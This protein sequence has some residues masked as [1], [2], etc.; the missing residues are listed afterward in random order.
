MTDT[1]TNLLPRRSSVKPTASPAVALPQRTQNSLRQ[2]QLPLFAA[3][4][5]S[6]FTLISPS[7]AAP[8]TAGLVLE[9][10]STDGVSETGGLISSWSDGSG[11]GN[12][13]VASGD[14]QLLTS[15]TP[16]GLPALRFD[17]TGDKLERLHSVNPLT[18][19]PV[20]NGDR[21]MFLVANYPGG[22]SGYAGATYGNGLTSQA[23]GLCIKH[24]TGE[25]VLQGYGPTD[26][27][28]STAGIGGGWMVQTGTVGGGNGTL[29]KD[30]VQISQAAKTYNTV[31]NKLVIGEEIGGLGSVAI[32]VAAVLIYNRELSEGERASVEAYLQTKYLGASAN[33]APEVDITTPSNDS[34]FTAGQSVT[35]SAT[36]T[37]TEDGSLAASIVWTSDLSGS[38]G[39][40]A[41][42]STSV[43]SEGFHTITASATDSGSQTTNSTITVEIGPPSSST[44]PVSSGLVLQLESTDGV[45]APGGQISQWSDLSGLGNHVTA[46]G[47]PQLLAASTPLGLPSL[48]LDGL[49]DKLE[50]VHAGTPLNG[51]PTGNADRSM[52][53][54]VNYPGGSSAFAGATYGNSATAQAFGLGIKHPSGELVLQGYGSPDLVSST[55]GIAAG[56]MVQSGTV[57]GGSGT[58]FKDGVQIEQAA[59]TYNT[60]LDKLVIGEEIGG[61]GFVPM[62]VAALLVYDRELSTSERADVE[63]YLQ[64]KYLTG[65]SGNTPPVVAINTPDDNSAVGA[66]QAINFTGT[67]IDLADGDVSPSIEWTSSIDGP[68]GT[69][70]SIS[71]STL[72]QGVHTITA[73]VIDSDSA[74][75]NANI[76]LTI[77][78]PS[79][80]SLV[81]RW[82]LDEAAGT[83]ATDVKGG[84]NGTLN[85]GPEW[86][87]AEGRLSG[88]LDLAGDA[89]RVVVPPIDVS[90]TGMTIAAWVKPESFAGF[91]DEARFVSKASGTAEADHYWMIGNFGNG[92]AVRFRLKTSDGGTSTLLSSSGVLTLDEWNHV[93]ATYNGSA[94]TLY[95][96]G[97]QVATAAKTGTI[98]TDGTVAV[99]LGNQPAGAGDRGLDGLLDEVTIY[100]RAFSAVEIS[101]LANPSTGSGNSAP[102]VVI[103]APSDGSVFDAGTSINFTA[104]ASD[105]EDGDLSSSIVWSSDKDGVLGTG[106][107]I[108]ESGLSLGA[109]VITASCTDTNS[110]SATGIA[111]VAVN[112]SATDDDDFTLPIVADLSLHL[113]ATE[114]V[115][116]G[117][118]GFVTDW[119]DQSAMGHSVFGGG[120]PMLVPGVTPSGRPVVRLDGINDMFERIHATHPFTL[121][122]SHE[123]RTLIVLASYGTQSTG[124]AGVTWGRAIVNKV[125]G[126][127]T[128]HPGGKLKL[129]GWGVENDF[130]TNVQIQG[131]GWMIQEALM[132]NIRSTVFRDGVSV[133]TFDHDHLTD[134]SNSRK[135]VIGQG[136]NGS[137]HAQMD[138]AAI[139]IYNRAL[140]SSERVSVRNYLYDKYLDDTLVIIDEYGDWLTSFGLAGETD[141]DSDGGGI[142]NRTEFLLG[143]DPTN[144]RDDATFK[145][146]LELGET[147]AILRYPSLKPTG[148]Y[149]LHASADLDAIRDPE[150]RIDTL[151]SAMIEAMDAG[152]RDS[153]MLEIPMEGPRG[154]YLLV[155]EADES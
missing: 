1:N 152:E 8:V 32:D 55:A 120:E 30:G 73:D 140:N 52:F 15:G 61:A 85:G 67:A 56:W 143:L 115:T 132:A 41:S 46:S 10:E 65:G 128:S 11:Q 110:P 119:A 101:G 84:R 146:E 14:P 105:A 103:T 108:T 131:A 90:G 95:V 63:V 54:V 38:L 39:T 37:D 109:H 62:N 66:G 121:P 81:S 53:M 26:L 148:S 122:I 97:T 47:D 106:A 134:F 155:F 124:G 12:D 114:G 93:A 104:T 6:A 139:L 64:Q 116:V 51:L 142:D 33:D 118:G 86:K 9:L 136:M 16:T 100:S 20:G 42:I 17:G 141:T 145:L 70:A 89:Q 94:M 40:G 19:L 133:G 112:I 130:E 25:I 87:P 113:E 21:T 129:Q 43:L 125:W 34:V 150:N 77:Q 7:L 74:A 4:T 80:P 79:D 5:L 23:F 60:V 111:N 98:T 27:V 75:G 102:Q 2:V 18:S 126:L 88:A 45:D 58:L 149:H 13:L 99:G 123:N 49:G 147:S 153:Y 3:A 24:P 71:V 144:S 78:E 68:L 72:T 154:F 135:L 92:S 28:S 96:N 117:A 151:T 29:F 48:A 91:A 44:L 69:G 35:F 57:G 82:P 76:T 137:G 59:R 50:R 31:L 83:V 138:I 22:S 107:S 36:A 127:T